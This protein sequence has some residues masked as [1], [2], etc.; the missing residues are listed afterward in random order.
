MTR[1]QQIIQ[2]IIA[3]ATELGS[4]A[5]T[6][7]GAHRYIMSHQVRPWTNAPRAERWTRGQAAREK[8]LEDRR[9]GREDR[10]YARL[11]KLSPRQIAA[12]N[13][14]RDRT[15]CA[16]AEANLAENWP[17][18][19]SESRWA[20]G[21]LAVSVSIGASP[22]VDAHNETVWSR[23]KKWSGN[24]TKVSVVATRRCLRIFPRLTTPDGLLVIDARKIAPREYE[25]TWAEQSRGVSL[26]EVSGWLIRG[27]HV[28]A[29]NVEEARKKAAKA[30]RR[31]LEAAL[32]AR[33]ERAIR[34]AEMQALTH[35]WVCLQDSLDAGN[36]RP[37]SEAVKR[38][39]VRQFGEIGGIRADALLRYRDDMWTRRAVAVAAS[40]RYNN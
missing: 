23:N 25:I 16:R 10:A 11:G 6:A 26:R 20:G 27:Y 9:L 30:R 21:E 22:S 2:T 4:S 24:N 32:R 34:N 18:R 5:S 33:Q 28:Q 17:Y 8:Y 15:I 36:C 19:R 38:A 37:S 31:A 14:K 7:K 13:A 35:I 40:N 29:K 3:L 12:R 39:L 1:K